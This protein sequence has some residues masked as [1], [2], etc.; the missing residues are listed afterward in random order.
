MRGASFVKIFKGGDFI[1]THSIPKSYID[2]N[3]CCV[4]CVGRDE[5]Y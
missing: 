1:G 3:M 5:I 2:V 4:V